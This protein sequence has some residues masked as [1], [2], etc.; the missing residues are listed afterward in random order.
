MKGQGRCN[1]YQFFNG[2]AGSYTFNVPSD[3]SCVFVTAT[4]AGNAGCGSGGSAAGGG[5]GSGEYCIRAPLSCTPG[6]TVSITLGATN[7][8]TSAGPPV[9]A[10]G[11]TLIT[12]SS[13]VSITLKGGA[14]TSVALSGLPGGGA[15]GGIASTEDLRIGF[16]ET[17]Y[18]CGGS[19]GGTASTGAPTAGRAGAG[20]QGIQGGA[21]GPQGTNVVR[22]GGGG[23]ASIFGPGGAGGNGSNTGPGT[24][25]D[26]SDAPSG[27]WGA[28]GGGSGGSLGPL[29]KSGAGADGACLIEWISH[30]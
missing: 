25:S 26:G 19:N 5:G 10:A 17:V 9:P 21:A 12:S 8:A 4:V 20:C 13:G 16:P 14:G 6:G 2:G 29:T 30:H 18:Q 11:D 3:V 22:A 28:G 1:K 23:A 7:P 15:R 27:S 24:G